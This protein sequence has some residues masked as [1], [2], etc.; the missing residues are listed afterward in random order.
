VLGLE[1][2]RCVSLVVLTL[3]V[4]LLGKRVPDSEYVDVTRDRD[5]ILDLSHIRTF[6]RC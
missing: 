6:R 1:L 5:Y 2:T 4:G 3:G